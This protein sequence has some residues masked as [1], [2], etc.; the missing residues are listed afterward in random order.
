MG[1]APSCGCAMKYIPGTH[2]EHPSQAQ[3]WIVGLEGNEY[4][5]HFK[6]DDNEFA[7]VKTRQ[8]DRLMR[9]FELVPL[10]SG[11]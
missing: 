2:W 10:P 5:L 6:I 3:I 4:T 8:M 9:D 7:Q 11:D 1:K